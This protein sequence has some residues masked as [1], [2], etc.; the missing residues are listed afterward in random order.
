[1]GQKAGWKKNK[2][3]NNAWKDFFIANSTIKRA[4]KCYFCNGKHSHLPDGDRFIQ[5]ES[6]WSMVNVCYYC[7]INKN[8]V[9][10]LKRCNVCKDFA[11]DIKENYVETTNK[12]QEKDV[13]FLCPICKKG[14]KNDN[15]NN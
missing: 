8:P 5:I 9:N 12:Y 3:T 10:I 15:E 2:W 13:L 6:K 11:E 7:W 1:M 14:I 4:A